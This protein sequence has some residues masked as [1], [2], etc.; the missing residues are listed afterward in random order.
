MNLKTTIFLLILAI[1]GGA[2]WFVYGMRTPVAPPSETATILEKDLTPQDVSRIEVTH[3]DRH[4][5]LERAADGEWT[6]PGKWP[7][8]KPEV[9]HLVGIITSLHSRF[10]PRPLID[11]ADMKDFGLAESQNPITVSVRAGDKDHRLQFG[12]ETNENNRFSR[13]TF[14][15][16]DDKSE[17][18]RLRPNLIADLAQ[19]PD[20][21]QQRRLFPAERVKEGEA[22]E[23]TE[24]LTASAITAHG[25]GS[26]YNL[27]HKGDDWE[28]SAPVHDHADPDKVK[29]ILTAV[30][31]IWAEEFV[32]KPEKDLA[33]YGLKE[34]AQRLQI[35]RPGGGTIALLVGKQSKM[36]TRTVT[37][38]AP[39]S[40]TGLPQ[41]PQQEVIHEEYRYAKLQDN[42]QI[43]EIKADKTKPIFVALDSLRDPR[44]ARFRTED[45]RRVEIKRDGQDIVLAKE[46]DQ[47]RLQK[48]L[49][50]DAEVS[51][52]N[53]LLDKLSGLEARGAD[54]LDK[55]PAKSGDA[56]GSVQVTVE[57]SKGEGDAKTKKTRTFKFEF[58][59]NETKGKVFA[60]VDGWPR[61]DVVDDAVVPLVKREPLAYRGRRVLDFLTSDL[62]K[63]DVH[64][65][66]EH[67][68]LEQNKDTWR[69]TTPVQADTDSSKTSKLTDELSRLEAVEYVSESSKPEDFDKLYGLAKPALSAT[70]TFTPK[71]KPAQ[72]LQIG[73][74]REGKSEYFAKLASA[75]GVFVVK[76]EVH[77]A[78]D[79][80]S[81]AYRPLQLWQEKAEDIAEVTVRKEGQE[82]RL[83]HEGSAWKIV[84]PFNADAGSDR[85][86]PLVDELANPRAERFEA[87]LAKDLN[88]YGLNEPYLRVV[89]T[90]AVKKEESPKKEGQPAKK[91]AETPKTRVLLIG[92]PTAAGAKSRFAKLGDA[93]AVFVVS[94]K[95]AAGVDKTALD[96][97]DPNLL[98]LGAAEITRIQS[99]ASADTMTVQ[100]DK[101]AW[102]VDAPP[103]PRFQ[104]DAEAMT[105]AL[106]PWADL[107]AERFVAYGPKA[108]LKAYGLDN[109]KRTLVVSRK[110]PEAKD[111]APA[112][113]DYTLTLGNAVPDM[114][115]AVYA[116]LDSG[117]GV[118]ILSPATA[119][120][121]QRTYLDFVSRNILKLDAGAVATVQR[122]MGNEDLEAVKRA[123]GWQLVK[124]ESAPADAPTVDK[125]LH[126]LADLRA[127]RIVA[128]PVKDLKPYG[129]DNP[130]AVVT[131]KAA[132]TDAKAKPHML[133]VGKAANGPGS[134]PGDRFVQGDPADVVGVIPAALAERLLASSLQF[135]D[136]TLAQV[137]GVDR[138]F[139]E[140]GPRKAVFANVDGTWKE[141]SPVDAEVEQADLEDFL[142]TLGNLRADQLV[143]DK[144][145]T[146][147]PYGLD[148]PEVRWR[149]QSGGKDMLGLLIGAPEKDKGA[150]KSAEGA[151]RYARLA[152][153]GPVFLLDTTVT[154]QALREYRSRTIW[155]SLDAAQVESLRY[156]YAKQPFTLEKVGGTWQIAG[157]PDV[158]VKS[159]SVSETLDALSRLRAER[160][161]VDKDADRKLYGL[162]PPQL[163]LEIGTP[164]GKR[165]LEVGHTE[166]S[167]KRHYARVAEDNRSE[168]FII[169]EKETGQILRGF[170]SHV[171]APAKPAP[172]PA[173]PKTETK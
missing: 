163:V 67:F 147:K 108:D 140:R 24:R 137:S 138:I 40:P 25:D 152:S 136:H 65:G 36:K 2:G 34:P 46:K 57:E 35:T 116:R 124:P 165:V 32:V 141:T 119:T 17:V 39:P 37:R 81:L 79:Q 134:A 171:E 5:I 82:Y 117:Q 113:A 28:L 98:A 41:Q 18:I 87:H 20:Y 4:L 114:P 33:T 1:A 84:A 63:I 31:D 110:A 123:E 9:D 80:G 157:K 88:S 158:K 45:A 72:T 23:R 156:G 107:R 19:P 61:L 62:A 44:L 173:K 6:L 168:V 167:S 109:P 91:E 92:K 43:F 70:V 112:K 111:K 69:L 144:P 49:S 27:V 94:D 47:W 55:P 120:E 73:K 97:L 160:Y 161:V 66:D 169:G 93:E 135:H 83:K 118:A 54:V 29:A 128:Y 30:P 90:A 51:K 125:L 155:P 42:E 76:K 16:I 12:E 142:K 21:Y 105:A 106:K 52:V 58:A 133:R 59:K 14:V 99:K 104:A 139:L 13:A 95:F 53:E 102:Q 77:D 86:R 85:V 22:T 153:G 3:G 11:N 132:A 48:P 170:A 164:S 103:V 26:D 127:S 101:D 15:R 145:A 122:H 151:R 162:E 121:L 143:A 7:T 60:R 131:L 74:Q 78:L 148:A 71:D 154:G 38:P 64:H 75:P 10:A 130:D 56:L 149:F 50:A 172:A 126:D 100:R 89:M 129:M 96:L 115:G 159:E 166:G 150:G 8:R 68:V 146:L